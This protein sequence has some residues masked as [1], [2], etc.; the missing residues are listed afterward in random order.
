[1]KEVVK[2]RVAR[3][4]RL[5]FTSVYVYFA[6]YLPTTNHSATTHAT[7]NKLAALQAGNA[8]MHRLLSASRTQKALL[9]PIVVATTLEAFD[10]P[11]QAL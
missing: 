6:F 7:N 10:A 5:L 1:L 9:L 4:Q 3:A 11:I 2:V 8:K